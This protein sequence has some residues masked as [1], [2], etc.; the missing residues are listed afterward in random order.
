MIDEDVLL[1]LLWAYLLNTDLVGGTTSQQI[2]IY[3]L[4]MLEET[5]VVFK[6]YCRYRVLWSPT[7]VCK[8]QNPEDEADTAVLETVI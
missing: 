6:A 4:D 3:F 8:G 2:I 7:C 1:L 5:Q